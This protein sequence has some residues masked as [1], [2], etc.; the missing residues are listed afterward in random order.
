MFQE[1]FTIEVDEAV[2]E[3][4]V[5]SVIKSGDDKNSAELEKKFDNENYK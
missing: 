3:K 5:I 4:K 1:I 2:N